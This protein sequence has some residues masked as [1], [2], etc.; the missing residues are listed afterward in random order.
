[1]SQW[2]NVLELNSKRDIVSGS[3]KALCDAVGRAADLRIYTEFRHNEHIDP[4]S[5][6]NDLIQEVSEFRETC[7][8][9]N[10]WTAGFMT[11][12]QPVSLPDRFGPRSSISYFLYNQNGQQ[13]IARPFLDGLPAMGIPEASPV[14]KYEEMPKYHEQS[15]WD[16]DTNAPS[17]NFIYDF[18]KFRYTVCDNWQEV[19]SHDENGELLS[20]S[21]EQLTGAFREGCEIKAGISGFFDDLSGLDPQ[22][23]LENEVFIQTGWGYYYNN[24]KLFI[25]ETHPLVKCKPAIPL[26]YES[27]GWNFGWVVLRS[28][29]A[30][31][32][33]ICDPYTLQFTDIER[34]YKIRWFIR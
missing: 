10:R 7:L 3:E 30:C 12:R 34:R 8:L 2:T 9:D 29:G 16:A 28:D 21:L 31:V 33:R 6:D 18:G 23:L 15:A 4:S 5:T 24:K 25:A 13:A 27:R 1:M 26:L 32:E 14:N 20:G 19:Y 22:S 17:S 11:L